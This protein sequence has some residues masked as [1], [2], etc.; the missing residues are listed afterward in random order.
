MPKNGS[1]RRKRR[2]RDLAIEQNL[3]YTQALRRSRPGECEPEPG[4]E[5]PAPSE[6]GL[7]ALDVL[8]SVLECVEATDPTD[9]TAALLTIYEA[10]ALTATAN[11]LID[12]ALLELGEV[13]WPGENFL[14]GVRQQHLELAVDRLGSTLPTPIRPHAHDQVTVLTPPELVPDAY[15]PVRYAGSDVVYE[16][17]PTEKARQRL[18]VSTQAVASANKS[19]WLQVHNL[20][21]RV[22]GHARDQQSRETCRVVALL[23]ENILHVNSEDAR[24]D[25]RT[26]VIDVGRRSADELV[27]DEQLMQLLHES[28][29]AT[30]RPNDWSPMS[31]VSAALEQ[32]ERD[33]TPTR[34]GYKSD[35][36]LIAA[37]QQFSLRHLSRK[38][39]KVT[40][41]RVRRRTG[42][43]AWGSRP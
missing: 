35:I 29:A 8:Q 4:H 6:I 22:L 21:G 9:T 40:E 38:G 36:K 28:V 42:E 2:A 10:L 25:Q 1:S 32:A 37:T 33:W 16:P 30:A 19:V 26:L 20:L 24:R 14:E 12:T 41:I 34:W 3:R 11:T 39:K 5:S 18:L 17:D 43:I 7:T 27:A 31:A 23:V 15:H 13:Y